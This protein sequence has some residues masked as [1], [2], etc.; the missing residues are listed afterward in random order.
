MSW[1]IILH[2]EY[3]KKRL[4]NQQKVNQY[5]WLVA[6]TWIHQEQQETPLNGLDM[7]LF[8]PHIENKL[9]IGVSMHK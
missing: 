6:T 8:A 9:K 4:L 3:G 5:R 2:K 7:N 1:H